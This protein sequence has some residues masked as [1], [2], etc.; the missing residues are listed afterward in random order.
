MPPTNAGNIYTCPKTTKSKNRTATSAAAL[1]AGIGQN[2]AAK[3][4]KET[5][6]LNKYVNLFPPQSH[7]IPL[8]TPQK[9]TR[10]LT[11]N[12]SGNIPDSTTISTTCTETP[13]VN[14]QAQK[15]SENFERVSHPHRQTGTGSNGPRTPLRCQEP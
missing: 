6:C 3:N 12:M 2:C 1:P 9:N 15:L 5:T 11:L 13:K 14:K 7:R 4:V 8:L 10:T